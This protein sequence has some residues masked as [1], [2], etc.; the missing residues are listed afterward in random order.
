V[1]VTAGGTVTAHFA[2]WLKGDL[3]NDGV[4]VDAGDEPMMT[5]AS[6]GKIVLV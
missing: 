5:D 3:N 4:V 1:T 6:V 2:L